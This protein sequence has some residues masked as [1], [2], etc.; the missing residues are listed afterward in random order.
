MHTEILDARRV[1]LLR[2]LLTLPELE[3]FYLAG[4]TA[5]S[6]QLG[7]RV[8]VDFDFFAERRFNADAVCAAIKELCPSTRVIFQDVDTCDLMVDGIQVSLFRYPYPLC[9]EPVRG[10][11]PLDRLSMA[12]VSDIAAMKLSA[13]GSRGSRKDFYDL[14]E[15]YRQCPSFSGERLLAAARTKFGQNTDLTY[16]LMGLTYF[17]DAES[18]TLPKLFIPADWADIKAFFRDE[19]QRLFSL[20][21]AR[22]R[23]KMT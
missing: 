1:S 23:K 17:D 10:N 7:L 4:G 20:E 5:L 22:F 9:E 19:Q 8:S 11:G 21:E 14:Y 16:M 18:E 2:A 12:S 3:S 15:I 6:L 13:I